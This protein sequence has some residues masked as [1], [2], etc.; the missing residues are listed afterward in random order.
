MSHYHCDYHQVRITGVTVEDTDGTQ[1][2]E[3]CYLIPVL[4][5]L[6]EVAEL[7]QNYDPASGTSPSVTY[8]R[9]LSRA[10]LDAIKRHE[11]ERQ[12]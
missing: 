3:D 9:P 4:I 6:S 7:L 8:S 5:P 10:I 12:P 11:E 2:D 1:V